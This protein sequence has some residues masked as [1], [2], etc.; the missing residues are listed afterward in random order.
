M[1]QL[2]VILDVLLQYVSLNTYM[3]ISLYFCWKVFDNI[4]TLILL[5]YMMNTFLYFKITRQYSLS[6]DFC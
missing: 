1:Y 2:Q 5:L 4:K 6:L 3:E